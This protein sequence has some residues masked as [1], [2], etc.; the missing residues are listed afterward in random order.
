MIERLL[1][2]RARAS[3]G[4]LAVAIAAVIGCWIV[5]NPR[6]SGPDEPSHMV[7]SAALVRGERDG[8]PDPARPGY[9]LFLVPAMVGAP[10]PAC[11]ST[12]VGLDPNVPVT[13]AT[14]QDLT[15]DEQFVGTSSENYPPWGLV[16][17]GLASY[18]PDAGLYTYLAR[19]LNALIPLALVAWSVSNLAQ[20]GRILG[21]AAL[22]GITPIAWF[23]FG[24]VNPSAVAISGGLALWAGLLVPDGR[25]ATTLA[26]AGWVAL[27][28]PRRDGP[29]WVLLI[30]LACCW[31]LGRRPAELWRDLSLPQRS[32]VVGA[33]LLAP[34]T[35]LWN[36][37]TNLNLA[38]SVAPLGLV[39]VDVLADQYRRRTN[40]D[41]RRAIVGGAVLAVVLLLGLAV[42]LRP[43]GFDADV[44][45]LVVSSTGEHLRQL[46]GVLGWLST[47]VPT[48]M[49]ILQWALL[50]GL[51]TVAYLEFR[52]AALVGAATLG[53][54]IVTAWV[55]ELGQGADYGR[56]W[57]GRYSM[58]LAVGLPIVLAW[59]A[60]RAGRAEPD[61]RATLVDRLVPI[62]AVVAW[63]VSNVAFV[64]AQQRWAVGVGG[65]W[66]PWRW[67]TW[68]PPVW[69]LALIV[70]HA[71]AS[72]VAIAWCAGA[73][74]E[75]DRVAA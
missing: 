8:R 3:A 52:R 36:R 63:V 66:Y 53:A 29:V 30:V 69:P 57:H 11:W 70:F 65:T 22:A 28:L 24:V 51:A 26:T 67:D 60:G 55:L 48:S 21:L 40:P 50:G 41:E 34:V 15:T 43:G 58:P 75:Q 71:L 6:S 68:S 42:T 32:A 47:P 4:W 5:G 37:E 14:T 1:P 46:V 59:R 23:T 18:V 20:H 27:M 2:D 38:L 45:R 61:G 56:Y 74:P 13:C 12:S 44:V 16:L 33:A 72:G 49:V 17:P 19:A 54:A 10:D 31:L 64:A 25:R 62:V 35:P 9:T 73:R 7:A 39:V